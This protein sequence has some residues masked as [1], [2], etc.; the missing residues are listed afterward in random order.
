MI[1]DSQIEYIKALGERE[2]EMKA[3]A[4]IAT[5]RRYLGT[6]YKFDARPGQTRNFDCSSFMQYIFGEHDIKLPRDSRQQSRVGR[7]VSLSNIRK[8]DLLFFT[9]S[10]RRN[11]TGIQ[12]IGH[13]GVYIGNNQYLNSFSPPGV[14]ITQLTASKRREFI[15][16]RRVCFL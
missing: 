2:M 9:K 4:I 15:T 6:P 3:N 16:A 13:V 5:G 14:T 11:L 7:Q 1:Y 10:S 12:R 8:G